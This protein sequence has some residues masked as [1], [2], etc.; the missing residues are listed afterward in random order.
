MS[1]HVGG[2]QPLREHGHLQVVEQLRDLLR[3]LVVALVLCG[4]PDLG[5]LLDD[6]LADGVHAGVELAHGAGTLGTG[7][8]FVAELDEEVV[9]GLHP[10]S[11]PVPQ[12]T[13]C[14][15]AVAAS[16]SDAMRSAGTSPPNTAD[17]ATNVS[18]PASAAMPMVSAVMPPSTWSQTSRPAL[19]TA[20]ATRCSFGI[21]SGMNDWPPK[22][23]STVIT[24]TWSN[25]GRRS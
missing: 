21:V 6:L 11:L 13:E 2:R 4:H 14:V 18:A 23:G 9:E 22:P 20:S 3:R 1:V 15:C 16:R 17:P 5:R 24:S 19:R 25:S 12:C 10:S 7:A 8:G